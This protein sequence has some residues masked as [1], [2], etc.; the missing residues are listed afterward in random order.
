MESLAYFHQ[1]QM[2]TQQT[3][4]WDQIK[5]A[6]EFYRRKENLLRSDIPTKDLLFQARPASEDYALIS[7]QPFKESE[8]G[9]YFRVIG[10]AD[11]MHYVLK[12]FMHNFA[13]KDT[14][15]IYKENIKREIDNMRKLD[16]PLIVK[17]L[18]IV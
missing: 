3:Q 17:M 4:N 16:H 10:K 15:K 14:A 2:M 8:E 5:A 12:E 11:N 9:R 6:N 13:S 18:D 1:N 7:N